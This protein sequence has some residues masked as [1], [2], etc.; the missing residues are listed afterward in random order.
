LTDILRAR[1]DHLIVAAATLEQGEDHLESLLGARPRR[2]GKHEAMGTHNSVLRLGERV[3]LEVIAIDP[4][5]IKPD[6]PRWFDL[7]RPSMRASLA[8]Q[9]RLI[10]WVAR[11]DDIESARN[12][13]PAD[14]G[15][16]YPMRRAQYSWRMTISEDGHLPGGG[17]VPTLIQWQDMNH[18]ADALAD[19]HIGVAALAG[20]HPEPAAIRNALKD[21]GLEDTLKVTYAVTPRLAAMLR[22]PRG[23]VAL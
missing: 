18:P 21:L 19:N 10:H 11:S 12:F 8:E 20:A 2:G 23:T 22:T 9:P 6:R 4:D 17:L 1:L 3:Y 15:L 5:G 14:H 13:S 16:V 7:D